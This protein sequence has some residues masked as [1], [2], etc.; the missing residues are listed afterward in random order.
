LHR[1]G[2]Q[3]KVSGMALTERE[4]AVL[5]LERCWWQLPGSKEQAIRERIGLSATRYY[6]VLN[7][8]RRVPRGARHDPLVVMRVRRARDARRR[9]RF[10]GPATRRRPAR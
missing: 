2:C 4:R 3:A 6:Q 7:S 8:A 1:L 10:E 5:D 9:A